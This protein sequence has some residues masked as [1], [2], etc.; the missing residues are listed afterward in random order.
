M[1]AVSKTESGVCMDK[2]INELLHLRQEALGGG[3]FKR[4][5]KRHAQGRLSARERLDLLLDEGSFEEF[6]M[7]KTHRCRNFGMEERQYPGDGVVTG[8]GTIKGRLVFVF[9]QDATVLGAPYPRPLRRRSAKSWIWQSA[10]VL[11]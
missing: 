6:D 8:Y 9:S 5:S 3:G 11:L 1:L 10:R 7:L 4:N 2:K